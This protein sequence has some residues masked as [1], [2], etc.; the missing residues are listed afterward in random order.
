MLIQTEWQALIN[1]DNLIDP[2]AE[3]ETAIEHRNMRLVGGQI[4]AV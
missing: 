4:L 2:V 1:R 3:Q